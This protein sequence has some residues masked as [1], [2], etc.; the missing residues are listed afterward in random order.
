MHVGMH[1]IDRLHYL[2]RCGVRLMAT[3]AITQPMWE[4]QKNQSQDRLAEQCHRFF[5]PY[6]C[7]MHAGA[8][9]LAQRFEHLS[10]WTG[11]IEL[12][13]KL[14]VLQRCALENNGKSFVHGSYI[15]FESDVPVLAVTRI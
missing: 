1:E 2:T 12:R 14:A 13:A 5:R 7:I 4:V 11:K 15:E 9:G 10:C 8:D 3:Q 6:A